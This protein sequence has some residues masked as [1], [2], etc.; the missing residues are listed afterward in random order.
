[1]GAR[2]RCA[3]VYDARDPFR[4]VPTYG[5]LF[6]FWRRPVCGSGCPRKLRGHHTRT[7]RKGRLPRDRPFGKVFLDRTVREIETLH[8]IRRAREVPRSPRMRRQCSQW[9]LD[10]L[11]TLAQRYGLPHAYRCIW[12]RSVQEVKVVVRKRRGGS[13]RETIDA[14]A[15]SDPTW[16]DAHWDILTPR[17]DIEMLASR[18]CRWC[19][20]RPTPSRRA[21]RIRVDRRHPGRRH[22]TSRSAPTHDEDMFTR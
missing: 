6:S 17:R 11:Q 21:A 13:P 12:R 15:G 20:V 18:G 4:Q 19:T 7:I 9:R 1:M 22:Q 10:Q 5:K 14:K 2:G 3:R 16:G 8:D